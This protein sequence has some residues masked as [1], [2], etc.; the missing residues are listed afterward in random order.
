MQM[1]RSSVCQI[2][3]HS[4]IK[5]KRRYRRA[6]KSPPQQ[7]SHFLPAE[8]QMRDDCRGSCLNIQVGNARWQRFQMS[9]YYMQNFEGCLKKNYTNSITCCRSGG[10]GRVSHFHQ[11]KVCSTRKNDDDFNPLLLATCAAF[12][13]C[14][15]QICQDCA[16]FKVLPS[17]SSLLVSDSNFNL[18]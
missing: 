17:G 14:R 18:S 11:N 6:E 16:R 2:C 12:L 10:T 15:A 13:S 4:S 1:S 3:L 9:C 7:I 8:L 5:T